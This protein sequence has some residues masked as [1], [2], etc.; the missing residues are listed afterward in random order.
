MRVAIILN[1]AS[2]PEGAPDDRP[3]Q[4]TEGF[5]ARGVEAEVTL[6]R[7]G[8]EIGGAV[9]SALASKVD[10]VVAGG[11]DGTVSAVA[12]FLADSGTVFGVLPLGTLNHFAKDLGLPLELEGAMDVIAAGR[13]EPVDAAEV[14]G[15]VFVNNSSIGLYPYIVLDRERQR[16]R[17][18]RG[19]WLALAIASWRALRWF[20]LLTVEID[21]DGKPLRR[22]TSFVFIG[23]NAYEMEGFDVGGRKGLRDGRLSLYVT[24]RTGRLGLVLLAFRALVGRLRQADDFD[25]RTAKSVVVQTRRR[26]VRVSADGEV[27]VMDSPLN[28]RIRA[29]AL[30]VLLPAKEG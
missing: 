18:G 10:A 8:D 13:T 15:R 26:R 24:Q 25:M 1:A 30:K 19:K 14:N 2:G 9:R 6:V 16:E 23:N 20:P 3:G 28:Y 5:K 17:L 29:G 11:G 21:A 7:S 12:G 22:R 4:I 27:T